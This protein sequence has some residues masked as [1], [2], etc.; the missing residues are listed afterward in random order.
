MSSRPRLAVPAALAAAALLAACASPALT[1][2]PAVSPR[3]L[4]SPSPVPEPRGTTAWRLVR[5]GHE[6]EGYA[7]RT[8]AAAGETVTFYVRSLAKSFWAD[9]YRLGWYGGDGATLVLSLPP[10]AG[11]PQTGPTRPDPATG[12]TRADWRPSF[13]LAIPEEWRSGM[14]MVKL[15]DSGGQES[16]VPLVVRGRGLAPIL[17]VHSSA[18]DEAYNSWGGESLYLGSTP[19]LSLPRAVKVSFDRPF[20][21]DFGAG[22]FFFWEYQMVRFLERNG[23]YA[24]YLTDVDVHEHPD[25]LLGYRAILVVG[26]DEYWS[27]SMRDAYLQAVQDGVNLAVFGGNTAYRQIRYEPSTVG[28]DRV[29]VCY[30][31]AARDPEPD[32]G[33]KTAVAWRDPPTS[34]N[35]SQLLGVQYV[36]TGNI[37]PLP[38][39]VRNASS[40]VFAG[41]GLK[42]GTAFPGL[43][44]YEQDEFGAQA[45]TGTDVLADSPVT[46]V[47]GQVVHS[48]ATVY[49]SLSGAWVFDTGSIQWSWG[50]D[51]FKSPEVRGGFRQLFVSDKRPDYS[52]VLAQLIALNVLEKMLGDRFPKAI[53]RP[54]P[55]PPSP[56]PAP[57]LQG[58]PATPPP[59]GAE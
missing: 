56:L 50:L 49:Q 5:P 47:Q 4:P 41:T 44:G 3:P 52:N 16:Y 54:Y 25:W 42:A 7:S 12:L 21:Q 45:P 58:P 22:D 26:H 18:T 34:W 55:V 24:D 20:V 36:G 11:D 57:G 59:E 43:L 32:P 38:W 15:T 31:D 37:R 51:G 8:S 1:A 23:L 28:E 39:V 40:W 6:T 30:K 29:I 9:V 19:A 35:E 10:M 48:H 13:Q 27:R 2:R 14:Y 33:L 46:T 53:H 17:F